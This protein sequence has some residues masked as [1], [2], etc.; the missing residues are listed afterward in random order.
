MKPLICVNLVCALFCCIASRIQSFSFSQ[1]NSCCSTKNDYYERF[2]IAAWINE[3][4]VCGS[5]VCWA[6]SGQ[7]K[8]V[9]IFQRSSLFWAVKRCRLVYNRHFGA[10]YRP[11]V[12]GPRLPSLDAFKMGR[13]CQT[14]PRRAAYLNHTEAEAWNLR[15][16]V[17]VTPCSIFVS[18]LSIIF[19]MVAV[20]NCIRVSIKLSNLSSP[21]ESI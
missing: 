5:R 14:D 2:G 4:W 18:F 15:K 9:R 21:P 10:A 13:R 1:K 20:Q 3:L 11:H 19:P 8:K 12:Q 17:L 7:M 16:S 6:I